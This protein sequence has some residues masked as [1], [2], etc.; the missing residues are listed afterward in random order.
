MAQASIKIRH[1]FLG[2]KSC[3]R[4]KNVLLKTHQFSRGVA[5][6]VD[7]LS[8]YLLEQTSRVIG[9]IGLGNV[10]KNVQRS[11]VWIEMRKMQKKIQFSHWQKT[12]RA[13]ISF[14]SISLDWWKKDESYIHGFLGMYWNPSRTYSSFSQ[15]QIHIPYYRVGLS[16]L[17]LHNID[18]ALILSWSI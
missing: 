16:Y 6:Q 7:H 13:L 9:I 1:G 2:R 4:F 12:C 17:F 5:V 10:P 15:A 18:I 14:T 8:T 11:N 3:T